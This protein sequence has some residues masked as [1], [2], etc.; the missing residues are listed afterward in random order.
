VIDLVFPDEF[1]DRVA[2]IND[3]LMASFEVMDNENLRAAMAHYPSAG[4]KRLR[5]LLATIVCEAFGGK[6]EM[7]VPFG[8]ALEMVHNFTLIHDD[9][10]DE[11]D[12]RR[13]LKTVHCE[14][15]LPMAIL[16][17]D[18]MFARAFEI[19]L[20]SSL[21]DASVVRLVEILARSVRLLA[22]G[23]QMDLDFED[24]AVV[25]PGEYLEM[26][27]RK[28]AVLYSA[29][30]QGGAIAGGASEPAQKALFEYGRLIGLGFQIWDDV[31][32]LRSDQETFGKPVLND[33][34]NGKK[35]L[36]VVHA[37]D[38]MKAAQRDELMSVLGKKDATDAELTLARDILEDVG[39]IDYASR[40][41]SEF[42]AKAKDEL[43]VVKSD[44][45]GAVLAEFADFMLS[46]KS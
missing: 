37:L 26:V 39:S 5:P 23:Q 14:Y 8:V 40:V 32:D 1:K 6:P 21:P 41:A 24:R 15:D 3:Q 28:T 33:I 13:G 18:A 30:A 4:G 7:A 38:I 20:E 19:V 29:A 10:M 9:V 17:G 11:D 27:E 42:I 35:T 44:K 36:I 2:T 46:R 25:S 16:A 34:R 45:H 12:T 22:D 31:L 43:K